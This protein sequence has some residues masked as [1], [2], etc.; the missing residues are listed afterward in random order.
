MSWL[1]RLLGIPDRNYITEIVYEVL[2]RWE[3]QQK[4]QAEQKQ[5]DTSL[6]ELATRLRGVIDNAA[7]NELY[8]A[9]NERLATLAKQGYG[10]TEIAK[11]LNAEGYRTLRG[12]KFLPQSVY[13]ITKR[14]KI[15]LTGKRGGDR[16][17]KAY[18]SASNI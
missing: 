4:I 15:P 7:H 18:K 16:R 11:K 10:C 9:T 13:K 8:D 12:K 14:M 6:N 3:L 2:E 5:L 17:S 1:Y